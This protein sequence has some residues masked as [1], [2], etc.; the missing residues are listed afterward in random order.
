M[1]SLNAIR[2]QIWRWTVVKL[3]FSPFVRRE[4]FSTYGKQV[5]R[6]EDELKNQL[7]L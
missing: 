6:V 5:G 4:C 2:L 7:R 1:G 3:V